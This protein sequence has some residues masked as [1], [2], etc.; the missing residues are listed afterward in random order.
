MIIEETKI[1]D[2]TEYNIDQSKIILADNIISNVYPLFD[3]VYNDYLKSAKKIKENSKQLKEKVKDNKENLE[4]LMNELNRVKKVSELLK[5]IETLIS[6]GLAFDGGLKHETVILLKII[7]KLDNE[8]LEMHLKN[9]VRTI[10]KR[11]SR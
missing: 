11:F 10:T 7:N 1:P 9:T 3:D 6:S 5:R 8:K 4:L 2:V